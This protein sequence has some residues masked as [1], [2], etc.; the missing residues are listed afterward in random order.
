MV[1]RDAAAG[2]ASGQASWM[3]PGLAP[4]ALVGGFRVESRLG[5]GGMAEVFQARDEGLDRVVALKVLTPALAQDA[6]FRER[7]I[8][9]SRAAARVEHPHIIPVHAAGEDGGVLY[10]AMRFVPGGDLRSVIVSE[11]PLSGERTAFL[12]SSIASALDAAHATG[13]VHRDVKPANILIDSSPGRPDHPYLSDF[14]LAKGTSSTAGMTGTGQFFGTPDYAAPEQ[15]AG[16]P[17]GPQTDQY[18]L[19]CVAY[20]MLS[21]SLP[22]ARDTSMAVLW[23]HMYDAPPPLS[24]RRHDLPSTVDAVFDRA[25]AKVPAQRFASCGEFAAALRAALGL[26]S[27]PGSPLAAAGAGP[28]AANDPGLRERSTGL[29]RRPPT[30]T[31]TAAPHPSFPPASGLT[32]PQWS[33]SSPVAPV[34]TVPQSPLSQSAGSTA[35]RRTLLWRAALAAGTGVVVV[36]AALVVLSTMQPLATPVAVPRPGGGTAATGTPGTTTLS[37][38]GAQ[39]QVKAATALSGLLTQSAAEHAGVNKAVADVGA[40]GQNLAQDPQIFSQAAADRH[41]LLTK[42]ARLPGRS[43]LSPVMIADLN[44]AWQASATLDADLAKWAQDQVGNCQKTDL[45]DPNYTATLPLDGQA[46]NDKTAFVKLW[47]PLAQEDALPTWQ[48]VQL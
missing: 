16:Q 37:G 39:T 21:G 27:Y 14:G 41:A 15:I 3:L 1:G 7:F 18:A 10:L 45:D 38:A 46:T 42:L 8:R 31:V 2:E 40:C 47:N 23:A 43:T 34:P 48:P 6:E 19:A 29:G 22:F 13:L 24:A 11:G 44:G 20:A 17:A 4:G 28:T 35:R 12:L 32:P 30:P 33:L 9:E 5:A 26:G 25:L 36:V